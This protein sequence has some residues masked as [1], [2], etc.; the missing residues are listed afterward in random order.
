MIAMT[1]SEH[2]LLICAARRALDEGM[3]KRLRQLLRSDLDWE[4]LVAMAH[5]HCLTPLLYFHLNAVGQSLVPRNVMSRLE[6]AN[7]RNTRANLFLTGELLRVLK[8]LEED[9]IRAVPFKGPTL[10]LR[11]YGDVGL[12]QFGDLDILVHRKDILKVKEILINRGFKST[13]ELTNT[14]QA[15]LLRFDC[16]YNFDNKQGVVLDVHWDFVE[17]HFS[18]DIDVNRVWDRLEPVTVS[19]KQLLTLSAEDLLLILCLHGFTHLW[20]RLGWI[21]D[22]AILIDSRKDLNWQLVLENATTLGAR[23]ILSLGLLL[24]GDLLDASIPPEVSKSLQPD[25]RVKRLA[26]QVREQLFT[27][28]SRP[29]GLFAEANTLVSL[30]E[31]RLDRL[32]SCLRLATTPRSYDW[33][34]LSVPDSL[35]FLYYLVRPLRLAGKYGAKLLGDSGKHQASTN[36]N[37]DPLS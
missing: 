21:C 18:F 19:G 24:A 14:Q 16:A 11:A 34:F 17:R 3:A 6:G 31:R 23:G 13:L 15:A 22:V 32:R 9:G 7:Y 20:E 29:A 36:G 12:R 37:A 30:R 8:L 28:R 2:E 1:R 27:E 10:A 26:G 33:M 35:F 5:N 4:Y 25:A